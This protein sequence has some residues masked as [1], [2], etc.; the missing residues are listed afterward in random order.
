MIRR[1]CLLIAFISLP[2]CAD[3]KKADPKAGANTLKGKWEITTASFNGNVS[4]MLKGR[5]LEFGDDEF[6]TYDGEKKGRTISFSL[7]LKANPKEIDLNRDGGGTKALGIYT[8]EKDELKLCYAEPGADRPKK[9]ESAAGDKV[10][11][12][13][14]K[15]VK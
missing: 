5:I 9:F 2:L 8:I 15:R 13:T 7:D 10:F 14:L 4:P 12:L 11:L 3:E 1:L 6:T